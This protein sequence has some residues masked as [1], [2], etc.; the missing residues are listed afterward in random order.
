MYSEIKLL[1]LNK[2]SATGSEHIHEKKL[3][4]F[5]VEL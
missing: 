1:F 4:V 3:E 2:A 5:Y